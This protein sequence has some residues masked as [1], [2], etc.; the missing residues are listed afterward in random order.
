[1]ASR[2][3]SRFLCEYV[4]E[5]PMTSRG[6]SRFLCE[7]APEEPM[8]SRWRSR[9]LCEYAP[10]SQWH[11]EAEIKA[12]MT[13]TGRSMFL[14]EYAPEEPRTRLVDIDVSERTNAWKATSFKY[15]GAI[16]SNEGSKPDAR[17]RTAQATAALTKLF[18]H[19]GEIMLNIFLGSKV[20]LTR[21]LVIIIQ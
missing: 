21:S 18:S 10:R 14:C 2:G 3:R 19:Y 5:E 8:A 6:R 11:P 16:V 15:F 20:K 17:S 13:S 4:P 12:P 7:Y 1:M 9:F